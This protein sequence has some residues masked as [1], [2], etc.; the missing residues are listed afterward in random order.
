MALDALVRPATAMETE[1]V[2]AEDQPAVQ[3][4]VEAVMDESVQVTHMD[5][6]GVTANTI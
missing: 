3:V 4:Q 1:H 6:T 5:A 2:T